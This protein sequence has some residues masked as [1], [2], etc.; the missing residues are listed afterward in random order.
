MNRAG[1]TVVVPEI[2][3]A[4]VLHITTRATK[5]ALKD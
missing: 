5:E 3:N 1:W 4:V 2:L